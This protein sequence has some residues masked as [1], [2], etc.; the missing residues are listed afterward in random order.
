MSLYVI[1]CAL[2]ALFALF[3]VLLYNYYKYKAASPIATSIA[4]EIYCVGKNKYRYVGAYDVCKALNGRLA[5]YSELLEAYKAGAD[6]CNIGWCQDQKAY[7][8]AQSSND[9]CMTGVIGGNMPAQLPLGAV[10]YGLKPDAV[11]G[12]KYDILPWNKTQ[13]SRKI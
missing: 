5:T 6:W 4:P 10:C 3:V 8:I 11:V 1:L 9:G 13:W 12:K 2:F 7:Y